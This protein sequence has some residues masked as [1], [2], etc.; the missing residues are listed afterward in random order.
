MKVKVYYNL[1]KHCFSVVSL[2]KEN[3]GKVID[4]VRDITLENAQ[5]KVSEAGRQRVLREKRKNVHAFVVGT[6]SGKKINERA[7]EAT[8]NPY[9]FS[10]FVYKCKEDPIH[11]ARIVRLSDKRI[12][13][14]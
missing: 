1:H 3:Y 4:H 12:F 7:R 13:V 14:N 11:E 9:K 2:N 5:F 10:T 6:I 8:Y